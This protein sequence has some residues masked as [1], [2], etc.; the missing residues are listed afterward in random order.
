VPDEHRSAGFVERH[1]RSYRN[2]VNKLS[3]TDSWKTNKLSLEDLLVTSMKVKN[4]H[5][6]RYHDGKFMSAQRASFGEDHY[7]G[8]QSID[9]G[10]S[11]DVQMR[12]RAELRQEA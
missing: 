3:H 6:R 12:Q 7:W 11:P 5:V 10:Q 1:N 8:E 4:S 2:I 9:Y